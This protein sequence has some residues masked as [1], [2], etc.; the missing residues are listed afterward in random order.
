MKPYSKLS[1]TKFFITVIF[2]FLNFPVVAET[3]R[4]SPENPTT[5]TPIILRASTDTGCYPPGSDF[6]Y[7]RT[8]L[9]TFERKANDFYV[10]FDSSCL[11]QLVGISVP[12]GRDLFIGRLP[13][14][15][16]NVVVERYYPNGE[17]GGLRTSRRENLIQSITV[18]AEP[19]PV[20][21]TGPWSLA[22]LCAT[23]VASAA[24]YRGKRT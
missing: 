13:A 5:A 8:L 20:P 2:L 12:A 19:E 1:K 18:T 7:P 22:L 16:Y 21:T 11:P 17:F 9:L 6:V 10:L 23:L 15:T 3:W 24:W 4:I 14:G